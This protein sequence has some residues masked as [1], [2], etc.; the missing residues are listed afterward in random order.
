MANGFNNIHSEVSDG[1]PPNGKLV[2]RDKPVT[3]AT[4]ESPPTKR[5]IPVTRMTQSR[6]S[7]E[8]TTAAHWLPNK[9]THAGAAR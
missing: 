8:N 2:A 1:P 3:L 4:L 5:Y 7:L 6:T 9:G